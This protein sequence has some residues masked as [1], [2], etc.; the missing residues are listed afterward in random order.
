VGDSSL[1]IP[2]CFPTLH[3]CF[4]R[5]AIDS[6]AWCRDLLP[7][8]AVSRTLRWVALHPACSTT[9]LGLAGAL[10]QIADCLADEVENPGWHNLAELAATEDYC[11]RRWSFQRRGRFDRCWML[12]LRRLSLGEP[13]L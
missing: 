6:I 9:Y 1:E 2:S 4:A 8:L 10:K 12:A 7:N 13:N 3:N 5:P 11:I